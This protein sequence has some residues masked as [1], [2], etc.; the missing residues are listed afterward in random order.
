MGRVPTAGE[1]AARLHLLV[2]RSLTDHPSW[3]I[4]EYHATH[5]AYREARERLVR[6]INVLHTDGLPHVR[7]ALATVLVEIGREIAPPPRPRPL[8]L[9][10]NCH[11]RGG[12]RRRHRR[13]R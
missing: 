11:H 7:D 3:S 10:K 4:D 6:V 2:Q 5:T 8:R 13:N 12:T 1:V 9:H